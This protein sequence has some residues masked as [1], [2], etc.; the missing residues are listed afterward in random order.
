MWN[1]PR[2]D[3]NKQNQIQVRSWRERRRVTH[4]EGS[5]EALR[6][7]RAFKPPG[8]SA[9]PAHPQFG[10]MSQL[11]TGG[12]GSRCSEFELHEQIQDTWFCRIQYAWIC[13]TFFSATIME[14]MNRGL[15]VCLRISLC[16][17][18]HKLMWRQIQTTFPRGAR[19]M[20]RSN[21]PGLTPTKRGV[22]PPSV[23]CRLRFAIPPPE[24]P[25]LP[26]ASHNSLAKP[27]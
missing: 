5:G 16:C 6:L 27:A 11:P 20:Q 21:L 24:T 15:S 8:S 3:H 10:G 25:S 18:P 26:F 12:G 22:T 17:S 13:C 1:E 19:D 7:G 23:I 9:Y 2:I 4:P 14:M